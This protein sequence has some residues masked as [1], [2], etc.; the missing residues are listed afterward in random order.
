MT[1]APDTAVAVRVVVADDHPIVR[2]GIVALLGSAAGIEVVGEAADGA[3]AVRLAAAL[4]PD[5]VLMD[6]RMP[7][8]GGAEATARILAAD[9]RIRILVLTTY[10]TDQHILGAIEA[11]AGGYLLKAAPQEEIIAGVRAVAAG[12]TVLAPSIATKLVERMRVPAPGPGPG[13]GAALSA[14][15]L[16]VLHLVAAGR[17]NPEIGR[18]LFIG[19]ATV[20]TH[21]Q[22]VFEKLEV[23]GRT[24]AVTRAME[25]GLLR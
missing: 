17:S 7:V 10:E 4:T 2:S 9:P 23:T 6:L 8:L 1:G 14:R 16:E 12:Q 24:R 25:L 3:E 21:L 5:V 18:L 19:E 15:E 11:G 13:S 22:H 20:K